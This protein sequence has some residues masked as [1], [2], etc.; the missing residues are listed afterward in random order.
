MIEYP[1]ESLREIRRKVSLNSPDD[2]YAFEE[3][4]NSPN[5]R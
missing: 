2:E 5:R 1:Q 4:I 3:L